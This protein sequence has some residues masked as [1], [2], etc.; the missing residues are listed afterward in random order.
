VADRE[1]DG[2]PGLLDSAH[3][4]VD[5]RSLI[6]RRRRTN[7]LIKLISLIKLDSL[8]TGEAARGDGG[9]GRITVLP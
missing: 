6:G 2:Q 9:L 5:E 8:I 3:P 7:S 1:T 4:S